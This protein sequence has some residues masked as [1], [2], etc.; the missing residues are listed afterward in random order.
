MDTGEMLLQ[1]ELA[2]GAT[3]TAPEYAARLSAAGAPL[4]A[5]TL[6]GIAGGYLVSRPQN[7]SQATLA[8][9]LKRE[10]GRIDWNRPAKEIYDRMRGFA[11][12]PGAYTQ[13]R[14]QTCHI[15]G[16]PRTSDAVAEKL[17]NAPPGSLLHET[18]TWQVVCG[19]GSLLELTSV[20]LEGR[21]QIAAADFANGARLQVGE[22][23]G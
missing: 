3:E 22:T 20:K 7:H 23:L 9:I 16:E 2:I 13:F 8:P 1:R 10:D 17:A 4:M 15:W 14:G 19:S 5:E 11:P 18:G 6:H 21:K 12:W